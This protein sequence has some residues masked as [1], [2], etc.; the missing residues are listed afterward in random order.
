MM[1]GKAKCRKCG[2]EVNPIEYTINGH[3]C[4]QCEAECSEDETRKYIM[5]KCMHLTNADAYK[6]NK[7]VCAK[8]KKSLS[9]KVNDE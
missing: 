6:N 7:L 3:M 8:C 2:K 1:Q 5:C 4:W 9:R